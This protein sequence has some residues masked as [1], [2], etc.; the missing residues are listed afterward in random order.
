MKTFVKAVIVVA[1][2][3]LVGCAGASHRRGEAVTAN[4][5]PAVDKVA[6]CERV[7]YYAP[8]ADQKTSLACANLLDIW[9]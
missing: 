2:I 5:T 8:D 3:A 9:Q 4:A 7:V 6:A 1:T